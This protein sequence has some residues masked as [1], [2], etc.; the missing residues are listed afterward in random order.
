MNQLAM[1]TIYEMAMILRKMIEESEEENKQNLLMLLA[2]LMAKLMEMM[3]VPNEEDG[4]ADG[5]TSEE[6]ALEK[7]AA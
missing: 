6:R 2:H 7:I 5:Q 1:L 4:V 3:F